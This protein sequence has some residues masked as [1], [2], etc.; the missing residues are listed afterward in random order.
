M[1]S[2]VIFSET[3]CGKLCKY[4]SAY[5]YIVVCTINILSTDEV[6]IVDPKLLCVDKILAKYS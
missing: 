1:T 4:I 2:T 3:L 5:K 6:P